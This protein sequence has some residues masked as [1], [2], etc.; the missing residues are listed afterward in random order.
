[1]DCYYNWAKRCLKEEHIHKMNM[2]ILGA[3]EIYAFLCQDPNFKK[4]FLQ[5]G[6]CYRKI[7][8]RWDECAKRFISA[9]QTFTKHEKMSEELCW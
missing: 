6:A 9:L 2:S 1:M 5:H 3:H 7:S 8:P 4:D